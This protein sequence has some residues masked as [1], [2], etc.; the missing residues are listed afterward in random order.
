MKNKKLKIFALMFF[1]LIFFGTDK[2]L[3]AESIEELNAQIETKKKTS[4]ELKKQAAIYQKNIKIKQQEASSLRN[5]LSILDNRIAK[6]ELDLKSTETEIEK[7]KLEERNIELE[8]VQ[9][10]DEIFRQKS[11]IKEL[12][13]KIRQNDNGDAI[14]ILL[15]KDRLSEYFQESEYLQNLQSGLNSSLQEVKSQKLALAQKRIDLEKKQEQMIQLKDELLAQKDELAGNQKH[16]NDLLVK[17][18]MSEQKFA[19]LYQKAKA[20]QQQISNDLAALEKATRNKLS[21]QKNN[22]Q[23]LREMALSWPVPENKIMATFHDPEYPYRYLF[24][25]P[26]IDIRTKQA[27]PIRAPS[28]GYVLKAKNAGMG[29]SYISLIHA[30]NLS[31]VYGHVSKIYVAD[32][33]YVNKGDIIGLSGGMPGTSGAGNLSTGP[34]LHFEVRINGIPVNPLD[35]LP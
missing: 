2:Q 14:K 35:Y 20:E 32:E 5:E 22:K 23:E 17:T 33:E 1:L 28:D 15:L 13:I 19:D 21:Q 34:H 8:I 25:H 29:Y 16:K 24:E 30:N 18:K 4:D 31:T 12:L 10:E 26:A 9:K 27:T 3:R 6:S 7:S 11:K